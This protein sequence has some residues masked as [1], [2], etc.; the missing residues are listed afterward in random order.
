MSDLF[1]TGIRPAVDAYLKA[2]SEEVRSYGD[3]WSAS[4]A[5]YCMRLNIMRRL[6]VPKVPELED[7]ATQT[8]IFEAGHIFHEWMQRITKNAGLSIAQ[9]VELQD[10]DLMIRGHFDDLVLVR[11]EKRAVT[12]G[13]SKFDENG[14]TAERTPENDFD[15]H[16]DH[17]IL[18]D[19]KTAH[20]A[21]FNY[22]KNRPMSHYHK[23]QLGTY[24]YMLNKNNQQIQD[25]VVQAKQDAIKYKLPIIDVDLT[26]VKAVTESRILSIS[27][28]DLRLS[29][30]QLMWSPQLEKEVV[31]YWTTLNGYWKAQKLPKCTC[32]D[33]EGG[34]MAKRSS[35]GK[36]YNDFF[37]EDEPCSLKW[38]EKWK[39][40]Q[41]ASV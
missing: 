22:A 8:R 36:V 5:G 12:Y 16:E 31:E 29:E 4:S 15:F 13:N 19:F 14:A 7:N 6:G 11:E 27:K 32:A 33:Y 1:N 23:Y 30:D 2:K 17:L 40:K 39:D 41:D 34:F 10:E 3:Y 20:S 28:D 18:Y 26:N 21:S 24:M 37:Y 35:K 9:E 38:Y 25:F